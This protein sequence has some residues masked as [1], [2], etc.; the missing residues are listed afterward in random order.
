MPFLLGFI[1]LF[2]STSLFA[3]SAADVIFYHYR[4]SPDNKNVDKYPLFPKEINIINF[5]QE[6]SKNETDLGVLKRYYKDISKA[7]SA[8][9]KQK[10]TALSLKKE[11]GDMRKVDQKTNTT[12]MGESFFYKI[13]LKQISK[14]RGDVEKKALFYGAL[15]KISALLYKGSIN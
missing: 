9:I 5:P 13:P 1:L 7:Y 2:S 6:I 4:A 14:T 3:R 10:Q 11:E 8:H 15:S 12:G